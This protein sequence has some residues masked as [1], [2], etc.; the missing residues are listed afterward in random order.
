VTPKQARRE[1][2]QRRAQITQ[3]AKKKFR[4]WPWHVPGPLHRFPRTEYW[5]AP[6]AL[7]R[8]IVAGWAPEAP[9]LKRGASIMAVGSCFAR[10]L[11]HY[12]NK[13]QHD[14]GLFV[15][16]GRLITTHAILRHFEWA[17]GRRE[18]EEDETLY[19]ESSALGVRGAARKGP[20]VPIRQVPYGG[21]LRV[22]DLDPKTRQR[23]REV[24]ERSEA[25]VFTLGMAEMWFDKQSGE[26]FLKA[27]PEFAFDQERHEHRVTTVKENRQNLEL[28]IALVRS[29]KPEAPIILTLSPQPLVATFRPV[30]CVTANMVSKSILRVA[31][32]EVIRTAGDSRLYYWPSYEIVMCYYGRAG[33]R[34]DGRHVRQEVADVIV[35]LFEKAFVEK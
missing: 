32:D 31:I 19:V 26:T 2:V 12:F 17:M 16:D 29:I 15:F 24:I 3:E 10:Q 1:R 14:V 9:V 7:E 35:R 20:E 23:T 27:V 8:F 5:K 33:Y 28:L 4:S 30:A 34:E 18:L 25:F 11:A 13:N 6:D 21:S 22:I